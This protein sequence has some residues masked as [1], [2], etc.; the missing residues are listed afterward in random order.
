MFKKKFINQPYIL[1]WEYSGTKNDALDP[2]SQKF[3]LV[4]L[5][6]Y[7]SQ[8]R[9]N[10]NLNKDK[11]PVI[12]LDI[13]ERQV[14]SNYM[15]RDSVDYSRWCLVCAGTF[16]EIFIILRDLLQKIQC[17]FSETRPLLGH[18]CR[19]LF[20]PPEKSTF[21]WIAKLVKNLQISKEKKNNVKF[22]THGRWGLD[23][24]FHAKKMA[25]VFLG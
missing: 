7:T 5:T 17:F 9:P 20:C 15:S 14:Y 6:S 11:I 1:E 13:V 19:N 18:F 12:G 2:S 3:W 10:L 4:C 23:Q 25:K 22:F 16:S 8:I 21:F 24:K